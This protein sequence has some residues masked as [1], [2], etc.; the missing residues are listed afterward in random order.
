MGNSGR[1]N[2]KNKNKWELLPKKIALENK[3][4]TDQ[5]TIVEKFNEF[6]ANAGPNVASKIAKTTVITYHICLILQ[7]YLMSKISTAQ[8]LKEAVTSLKPN[9]NPGCDIIHVNVIKAINEE[10]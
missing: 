5:K 7:H 2:W 10:L 3:E 8:E 1:C 9:K 6:Y 4:I